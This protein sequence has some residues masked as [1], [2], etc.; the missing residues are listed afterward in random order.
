MIQGQLTTGEEHVAGLNPR[1]YR[2][3]RYRSTNTEV[4]RGVLDGAFIRRWLSLSTGR[5]KEFASRA[6]TSEE[7]LRD[8]LWDLQE[9]I[10]FF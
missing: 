1:A 6:G 2:A 7:E 5:R 4:L 8:D 3:S 10:N 9:A